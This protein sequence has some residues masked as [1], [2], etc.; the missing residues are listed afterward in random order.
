MCSTLRRTRSFCF[1]TTGWFP[2]GRM[3]KVGRSARATT[4]TRTW[5]QSGSTNDQSEEGLPRIHL[6]PMGLPEVEPSCPGVTAGGSGIGA[7][8]S[9]PDALGKVPPQSD[10]PTFVIVR[11]RPAVCWVHDFRTRADLLRKAAGCWIG[12]YRRLSA[13]HG[14]R[15]A[16]AAVPRASW[17]GFLRLSLVSCP[18][19]LSPAT[20]RTK[21]IRLHEV[22][23]P[24]SG[25]AAD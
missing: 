10:L 7:T 9:L 23:P 1:G 24:A 18:I 13:P 12:E 14:H 25:V 8:S 4:S 17:K 15:P 2:T 19:Y 11:C 5:R 16:E 3:S 6:A 20:T 21:S 22:D